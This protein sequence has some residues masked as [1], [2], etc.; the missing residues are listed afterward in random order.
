MAEG[1]R[2]K[3]SAVVEPK[4]HAAVPLINWE[5]KSWCFQEGAW[6]YRH[7]RLNTLERS[8]L[9]AQMRAP[10]HSMQQDQL[11]FLWKT[12]IYILL[13][14]PCVNKVY[15]P[16]L[17]FFKHMELNV[18]LFGRILVSLKS[19][20]CTVLRTSQFSS[21]N[22]AERRVLPGHESNRKPTYLHHTNIQLRHTPA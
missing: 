14:C 1:T 18:S 13:V 7:E 11:G 16:N 17:E 19:H 20:F 22:V 4:S 2:S 3:H 8:I 21:S 12:I 6:L 5:K 9:A 15:V 10:S